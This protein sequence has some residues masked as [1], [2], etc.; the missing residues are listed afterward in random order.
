[1]LQLESGTSP[2][3]HL[4]LCFLSSFGSIDK[5]K[6]KLSFCDLVAD[7][8]IALGLELAISKEF[9]GSVLVGSL[10]VADGTT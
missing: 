1:M 4:L 2:F 6:K 7:H 3:S 5:K 9:F 10:A 8:S